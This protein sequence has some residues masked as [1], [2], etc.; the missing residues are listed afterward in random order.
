MGDILSTEELQSAGTA[1]LGTATDAEVPADGMK[2]VAY[3][4][5]PVTLLPA[6]DTLTPATVADGACI[7]DNNASATC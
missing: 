3:S 1:E 4:V 5:A 6:D 2:Y 7:D